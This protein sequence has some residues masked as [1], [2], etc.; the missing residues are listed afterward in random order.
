MASLFRL[1]AAFQDQLQSSIR[2]GAWRALPGPVIWLLYL[3]YSKRVKA[4]YGCLENREE[5]GPA[6]DKAPPV[7]DARQVCFLC[8]GPATVEEGEATICVECSTCGRYRASPAAA[9]AL[10]ALVTYRTPGLLAMR[11]MLATFQTNRPGVVPTIRLKNAM[12]GAT[13][14]CLVAEGEIAAEGAQRAGV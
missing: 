11:K 2:N 12:E 13:T 4:T 6:D 9:H 8:E 1:S 3:E 7:G 14:W 5:V 10:D